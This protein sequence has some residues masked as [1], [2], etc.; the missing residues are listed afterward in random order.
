MELIIYKIPFL[1]HSRPVIYV[2]TTSGE[3]ISLSLSASDTIEAV[4]TELQ[5]YT[6]IPP[7]QQR[8]VF[9]G[10]QLQNEFKICDYEIETESTLH[11]GLLGNGNDGTF[12]YTV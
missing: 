7:D 12:I 3:T 8:L 4:K 6:L 1:D 10:T 9:E 11:L 2:K 5:I